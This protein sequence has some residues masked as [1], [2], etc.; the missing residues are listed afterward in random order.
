MWNSARIAR[1][2]F[3]QKSRY[4]VTQVTQANGHSAA[5][6]SQSLDGKRWDFVGVQ[7]VST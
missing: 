1:L 2:Y 6:Q 7:N 5:G 4:Y 3:S